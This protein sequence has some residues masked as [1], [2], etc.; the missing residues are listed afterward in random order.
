MESIRKTCEVKNDIDYHLIKLCN[1]VMESQIE[2]Y[3]SNRGNKS[4]VSLNILLLA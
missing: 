4:Q 1:S 2:K 3:D